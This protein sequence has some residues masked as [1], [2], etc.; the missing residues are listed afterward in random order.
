M[1]SYTGVEALQTSVSELQV[2]HPA[3]TFVSFDLDSAR[4]P[5]NRHFD[6][7]VALAVIEHLW[8]LKSFFSNVREALADDGLFVL[9]TP[10]P[11]GNHI[12]LRSLALAGLVRKD[13]INDHVAIFNKKLFHHVCDEFGFEL[14]QYAK[15]QLGGNQ[16][17]VLRKVS[18]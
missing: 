13:V 16:L 14:D 6:C 1:T 8:N 7:V 9:T 12:V 3:H 15:F 4:W 17:A 5:L 10:T 11:F 2:R 18:R